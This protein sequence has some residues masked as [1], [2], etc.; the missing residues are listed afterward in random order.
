MNKCRAR[1]CVTVQL[2]ATK[3][4]QVSSKI[5]FRK[6]RKK[7]QGRNDYCKLLQIQPTDV[8]DREF[9]DRQLEKEARVK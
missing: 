3:K 7:A 5:M 4:Y 1:Y 6:Q 2:D 8:T 9:N